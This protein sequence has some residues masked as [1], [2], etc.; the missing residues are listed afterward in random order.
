VKQYRAKLI[1]ISARVEIV[2]NDVGHAAVAIV[3]QPQS[4]DKIASCMQDKFFVKQ[5]VWKGFV[6]KIR[7]APF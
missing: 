5:T 4:F 6:K 1:C 7:L 2:N 3:A